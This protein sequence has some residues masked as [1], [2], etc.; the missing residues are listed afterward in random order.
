M[1]NVKGIVEG[2]Q[3]I[4]G[5]PKLRNI[6]DKHQYENAVKFFNKYTELYDNIIA[7]EPL[8]KSYNT[9]FINN[10]NEAKDF[11]SNLG[12]DRVRINLDLG[13]CSI[14]KEKFDIDYINHVH[15]SGPNLNPLPDN[16]TYYIDSLLYLDSLGYDGYVSLESLNFHDDINK[17]ISI[18]HTYLKELNL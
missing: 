4:F 5:N 8:H 18:I 6:Y 7:I 12:N 9:N 11:V 13:S 16:I 17:Y 2:F 10:Y 3:N 15:I 14:E 1:K